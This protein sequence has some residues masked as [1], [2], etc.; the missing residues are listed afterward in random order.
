MGSVAFARC[1]AV[2]LAPA[3]EA[4]ESVAAA[5]AICDP[6]GLHTGAPAPAAVS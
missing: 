4:A 3:D 2:V 6:S 1:R 5:N